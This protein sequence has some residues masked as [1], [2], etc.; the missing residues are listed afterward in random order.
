MGHTLHLNK[1][2]CV[3]LL[4]SFIC[5]A[6]M[7]FFHTISYDEVAWFYIAGRALYNGYQMQHFYMECK[8]HL[9]WDIPWLL[10]PG[11]TAAS[12]FHPDTLIQF[13]VMGVAI[14]FSLV[15]VITCIAY[16]LFRPTRLLPILAGIAATLS[17]GVLPYM[18]VS[19]RPDSSVALGITLLYLTFC[20][21]RKKPTIRYWV[22][23][24]IIFLLLCSWVLSLHPKS[25]LFAPALAF[26]AFF[27][28]F[29]F[30]VTRFV[31]LAVI[32][33]MTIQSYA[34]WQN[35][36]D[37][38]GNIVVSS[39]QRNHAI[40]FVQAAEDPSTAAYKF[41]D[42]LKRVDRYF[43]AHLFQ[44]NY[45]FLNNK[46]NPIRNLSSWLPANLFPLPTAA[47]LNILIT[48][49][50]LSIGLL[51]LGSFLSSCYKIM[52]KNDMPSAEWWVIVL[53]GI[54]LIGFI[55]VKSVIV[56]YEG[57]FVWPI[58]ILIAV[59]MIL[60][61]HAFPLNNK[62]VLWFINALVMVSITSQAYAAM[63]LWPYVQEQYRIQ[64]RQL[65]FFPS[66][67]QDNI[68]HATKLCGIGEDESHKIIVDNTTYL[69]FMHHEQVIMAR[70]MA[71][72]HF[73]GRD[74]Q[75]YIQAMYPIEMI[76]KCN[77]MPKK[78]RKYSTKVGGICC[79]SARDLQEIP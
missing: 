67:R 54:S 56:E 22:L 78:F 55:G 47:P 1:L 48:L 79:L 77:F 70:D 36:I 42:N 6:A 20:I 66:Y 76:I 72:K 68:T 32:I 65:V 49:M 31:Y 44:K 75:K 57:A 74:L 53:F 3:I 19:V 62:F 37:C 40:S 8:S 50:A 7:T 69:S 41:L 23:L 16:V 15:A 43:S 73:L 35:F 27:L 58:V 17:L 45:H 10:L 5:T 63:H 71:K 51:A 29:R 9:T 18:M 13:R 33:W 59:V 52:C 26:M 24:P 25:L 4:S 60:Y 38:P 64:N 46:G 61:H 39:I 30:R 34:M 11:R 2:L 14:Y 12:F 21:S 28:P